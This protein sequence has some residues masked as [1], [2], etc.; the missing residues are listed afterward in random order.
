MSLDDTKAVHAELEAILRRHHRV[1]VIVDYR[2]GAGATPESRRWIGEWNERH[3]A[4]GVAIFGNISTA[5]R[6]IISTL[7]TVIRFCR[8]SS[9]PLVLVRNEAEAVEW[10]ATQRSK[11][12]SVSP[13]STKLP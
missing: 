7:F 4:T 5:S 10:V 2:D 13:L 9:L 3:R 11:L 1:F 12:A 8:K 6:T